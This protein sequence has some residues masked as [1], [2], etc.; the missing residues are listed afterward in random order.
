LQCRSC[1][2]VLQT[3]SLL[4][5]CSYFAYF[6]F[7]HSTD[8]LGPINSQVDDVAV[9][10]PNTCMR[11][12]IE[13]R[14]Q[15]V[16]KISASV[17]WPERFNLHAQL[18]CVVLCATLNQHLVS[19]RLSVGPTLCADDHAALVS[20]PVFVDRRRPRHRQL[21]HWFCDGMRFMI[22][23]AAS[24]SAAQATPSSSMSAMSS[25]I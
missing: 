10:F 13:D 21:D 7:S 23:E 14:L 22:F 17:V 18:A 25:S 8:C 3:I 24:R 6:N 9:V 4:M 1:L 20:A 2:L 5:L 15:Q 12:A 11:A 16:V 19:H